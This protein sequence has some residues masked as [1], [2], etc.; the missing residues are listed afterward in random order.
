MEKKQRCRFES[1]CLSARSLECDNDRL[2]TTRIT[3]E[4]NITHQLDGWSHR[5]ERYGGVMFCPDFHQHTAFYYTTTHKLSDFLLFKQ[6]LASVVFFFLLWLNEWLGFENVS[7]Q[8][9]LWQCCWKL[10]LWTCK[11][12][13]SFLSASWTSWFTGRVEMIYLL[14]LFFFF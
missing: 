9:N 5:Q 11:I 4:T 12:S 13:I 1:L 2:I 3:A 8:N 10:K 7:W 6:T 14:S